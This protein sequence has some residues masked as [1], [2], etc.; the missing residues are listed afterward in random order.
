MSDSVLAALEQL[1]IAQNKLTEAIHKL[2]I[3]DSDEKAHPAIREDIDEL[4]SSGVIYTEQQIRDL[5]TEKLNLHADKEFKTAHPGWDIFETNLNNA[6][7]KLETRI[8]SIESRL[9]GETGEAGKTELQKIL[10]RI[11]DKYA[12]ILENLQSAFQQAYDAGQEV[13]AEQYKQSINNTLQEKK[14]EMSAAIEEYYAGL[15]KPEE[16]RL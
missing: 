8:S 11:E 5:I 2:E 14:D 1:Q 7:S 6:L 15:S 10:Q 4:K 3:H 9:D 13:L 16:N 12:P